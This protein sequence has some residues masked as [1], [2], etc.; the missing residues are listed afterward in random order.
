M[1]RTLLD[2]T[3][4]L[5]NTSGAER[6]TTT[7]IVEQANVSSGTFYRYFSD[8]DE[9]L[10][11][12]RDEAVEA[13]TSELM[14]G[15]V[16]AL[17][18]DLAP[19]IREVVVT[20]VDSFELHRAVIAAVVDAMPAGN[21][22]NILPEVEASL[23]QLAMLLPRRH[24]P[25]LAAPRLEALVF[26]TMGVLVSTCLRIAL[27]RPPDSSRDELVDI[28]AAMVVGGLQVSGGTA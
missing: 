4:H 3:V 28:A 13:I 17:D 7:A 2:T 1:R 16:R 27:Q 19:A 12:L 21:N 18:L 6:L 15:V 25:D 23:F 11:V 22:A 26:M 24:R 8:L 14:G 20:L 9:I 5:L 10:G